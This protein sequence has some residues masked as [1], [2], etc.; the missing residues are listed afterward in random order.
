MTKRRV[1]HQALTV[2]DTVVLLA[3]VRLAVA[4]LADRT[5]NSGHLVFSGLDSRISF[6][7][8][9]S[10]ALADAWLACCAIL[11]ADAVQLMTW[12]LF[13]VAR[14]SDNSGGFI[15]GQRLLYE[16]LDHLQGPCCFCW[17]RNFN[18]FFSNSWCCCHNYY[19]LADDVIF[20]RE[21]RWLGHLSLLLLL[22]ITNFIM[23]RL[24]QLLRS[25]D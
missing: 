15:S 1:A 23:I 21:S 4:A 14:G 3:E 10:W 6:V 22:I 12:A 13:A 19:W 7:I 20:W 5:V 24:Q 11:Q 25:D 16:A 18:Y 9:A 17:R 2:A 8:L